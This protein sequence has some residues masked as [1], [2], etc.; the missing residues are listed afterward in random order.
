[1]K[2]L[3]FGLAK[4]TRPDADGSGQTLMGTVDSDPAM[5]LGTVG[6]MSPEQARGRVADHR[7][8]IFA[9]GAILYEMVSGRRAF[10]G[11]TAADT[12]S[13][14]LKEDPPELTSINSRVS[15]ALERI[16][17]HCLEKNPNERFMSARDIAFDLELLSDSSAS[18]LATLTP[19]PSRRKRWIAAMAAILLLVSSFAMVF[20]AGRYSSKK[21]AA[22]FHRLTFRRGSIRAARFAP[23]GQ[24]IVYGAAWAGKPVELFTTRFD[25]TDSRSLGLGSGQ[26]LGISSA[27]EL[28]VLLRPETA[29]A[30]RQHGNLARVPLAGGAPREILESVEWA[31][32]TPDGGLAIVR[33]VQG[34]VGTS[35]NL[36]ESPPGKIIYRPRAWVSHLRVAPRGK[37]L[38]F[39][40]HVLG[41]DNG[42]VVVIDPDGKVQAKSQQYSS[43]QGVAWSADG[44]EVWFTAAPFG[45]AR[46]LYAM[47]LSGKER[48]V[49]RVPSILT[50]HDISRDGRVL[51][52]KDD[53]QIGMVTRGPGDR[54]ERDISW[55]DWSL[56]AALSKD[57]KTVVFSET[58]EAVGAKYGL[59]LRNIDGSPAVRLGNGAFA[60]LS[61]DGQWVVAADVQSPSQLELL[62]TRVGEPRVITHDNL[63][64]IFPAWHPDGTMSRQAPPG[65]LLRRESLASRFLRTAANY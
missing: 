17:R 48:L 26:I 31:D 59:Y 30:F 47:N 28:A 40:D 14:I 46:A 53:A 43:I 62:P 5:L 7:S 6:Y 12:L 42:S 44:R 57:G 32:W 65:R 60:D 45:A 1:V 33:R 18:R 9:L 13:A 56:L 27:S 25:S 51:L 10:Q 54:T 41:G 29:E 58:G 49:L 63:E 37:F 20:F 52:G 35:L 19:P 36:I 50:L 64:H 23:D 38:A 61:P 55:F 15:P 2:I 8:D 3:D 21:E 34:G 16:V 24:T 11:E 39:A 22:T 4:L